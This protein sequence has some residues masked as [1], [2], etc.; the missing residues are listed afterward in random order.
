VA[1]L[2]QVHPDWT[3]NQVRE[4]LF[5]SGSYFLEFG[6][7]DPLLIQGYGIPDLFEAAGLPGEAA[8]RPTRSPPR[9]GKRHE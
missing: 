9:R 2:L 7:P 5:H 4:A 3:V 1:C 8:S 6:V